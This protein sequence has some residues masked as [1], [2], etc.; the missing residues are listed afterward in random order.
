MSEQVAEAAARSRATRTRTAKRL[1]AGF[2]AV[3]VAIPLAMFGARWVNE[4]SHPIDEYPLSWQMYSAV[5]SGTYVGLDDDQNEVSLSTKELPPIVRGAGYG[6]TVPEM[7]CAAHPELFSVSRI[8]A[9]RALPDQK[10][11]Y[12]C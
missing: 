8:H 1:V 7:L 3:Q 12:L 11:P 9:D 10:E 2:I 5:D 6:A 4:G